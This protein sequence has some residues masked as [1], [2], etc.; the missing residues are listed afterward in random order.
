MRLIKGSQRWTEQFDDY[1]AHGSILKRIAGGDM[2]QCKKCM[3]ELR[4]LVFME[5]FDRSPQPR[6]FQWCIEN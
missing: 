3:Q 6:L 5:I 1:K 2:T 4:D